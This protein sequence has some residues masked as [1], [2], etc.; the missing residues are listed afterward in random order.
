MKQ[1]KAANFLTVL[2]NPNKWKPEKA[3]RTVTEMIKKTASSKEVR[4]FSEGIQRH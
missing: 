2:S 4:L 3:E 1:K